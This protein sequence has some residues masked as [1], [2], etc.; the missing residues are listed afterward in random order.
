MLAAV[1]GGTDTRKAGLVEVG[2]RCWCGLLGGLLGLEVK[3]CRFEF[4]GS[5]L[6][7]SK[8]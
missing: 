7:T 1:A 3:C 5:D 6:R 4:I 2:P 8:E